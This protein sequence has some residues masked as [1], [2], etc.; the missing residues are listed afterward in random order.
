MIQLIKRKVLAILRQEVNRIKK[1][2]QMQFEKSW[3]SL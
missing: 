2:D 3:M 1:Q